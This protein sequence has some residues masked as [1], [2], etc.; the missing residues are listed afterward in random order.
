M[1]KG[2]LT[3]LFIIAAQTVFAQNP[4]LGASGAQFLQIPI[5]S[6]AEAM[7]GAVVG[8]ADDAS[9]VFWNPAG[10]VKV[11]NF[12][13]F[14]SYINWFEL[15]DLNAASIVYNAGE[16]GSFG[17]SMIIFNTGKMEITT[18]TEPNGTGRYFDA[19]DLAIGV[20]YARYLTDRFSVGV[21]VKYVYQRIWNESSS[22]IAFD[23]GT[24]YKLDFQNL[25]IAM[26]MT[27]FGGDLKYDGSD[28][29]FSHRKDDNFPIS[30]LTPSRLTTEEYP[31][32]LNFQVGIGFDVFEYEFV[33]MKGAIDVTHPNDNK[34]RAHFG[35][36][37]S[38]FDRLYLRGGYKLNYDD[39]NVTFG[40]GINLLWGSNAVYFDYAYSV[41]DI[42][43]AVHRISLKLSL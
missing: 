36:E 30:R 12:Q 39:Q 6:R 11:N 27:N 23:L 42:L 33:K 18:E 2:L 29:D 10:I 41:Y 19:G 43:P 31:L 9:A 5:G 16:L 25:T 7:G 34:E 15:F 3:L 22:G 28:L 1:K 35:T 20:S 38:F 40:A 26:A 4:N 8:L 14:F 13:V 21:S 32:P 24:Q 37:F 17:A